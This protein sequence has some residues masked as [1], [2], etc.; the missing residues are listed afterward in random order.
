MATNYYVSPTGASGNAGTSGSP[1][2]VDTG[3]AHM[4]PDVTINFLPGTYTSRVWFP[5]SA[6]GS[7]GHPATIKSTVKWGAVVANI[8][9]VGI[10]APNGY[11]LSYIVIDGFR[12][13]GCTYD[14]VG[15]GNHS[16]V[17]NCWIHDNQQN[18]VNSTNVVCHDNLFEDNLIEYNGVDTVSY[19][20]HYHNIYISGVNNICRNNVIRYC[21]D[22]ADLIVYTGNVGEANTNNQ[23]YNNLVV[24]GTGAT[25]VNY[26][27]SFW[28]A[29]VDGSTNGGSP[30]T[31]YVFDNTFIGSCLAE[32][33]TL[34]FANNVVVP[35]TGQSA[36]IFSSHPSNFLGDYNAGP[37]T[38]L[39]TSHELITSVSAMSFVNAAHGL[40]WPGSGSSLRGHA[41][42]SGSPAPAVD[43]FGNAN[44]SITDIGFVQYNS[45][46]AGDTRTLDPSPSA[47]ADYWA[48]L[49]APPVDVVINTSPAS[50]TVLV[51]ATATFSVS[52]T[53]NTTL[54]Y[55]WRFNG[56]N[57]GTNSSTYSRTNCQLADSGGSVSVV[58]SDVSG[59]A[60]S[61]TAILTVNS[62]PPPPPPP[63]DIVI[64]QQPSS[65]S[66]QV[67]QTANFSVVA[68]GNSP[69][70]T[71]QWKFNGVNVGTNSA[72]YARTNCQLSDSGSHVVVVVTDGTGSL[73][74]SQ[75][76]LTVTSP[77]P[78]SVDVVIT[79]QPASTSVPV[80]SSATFS[81][82]ATGHTTLSY[83][84][85]FKGAN[86]GTNSASYTRPNC[87]QVDSGGAVQVTISDA[88][89]SV[90]S[91]SATLTVVPVPPPPPPPA[92]DIVITQPLTNQFVQVGQ[93][94][95]F[96]VSA[97]G[98][99]TLGYQWK[100]NG[101]TVGFNSPSYTR[102]NCQ[103]AD[104]GGVVQVTISD[105]SGTASSTASLGVVS[106][107]PPP[108]VITSPLAN[109][110]VQVGDPATFTV[111]ATGGTPTLTYQWTFNG[112]SVGS[113]SS[114]YTR[115]NCQ[116]V[117]NGG[118]VQVRVSNSGG[119]TL[120]SAVLG[121][122]SP[123]PPPPPPTTPDITIS[124]APQNLLVL[125]GAAATF[126]VS[127]SS[128][129]TLSYQWTFNG[130]NV[131]TNSAT[132][133]RT[134]CQLADDGGIVQVTITDITGS[135]SANA[136][137]SVVSPPPPPTTPD[138]IISAAP[139]SQLVH[140]GDTVVFS[141]SASAPGVLGYQWTFNG[142]P[143]G[144]NL[145]VYAR[146][147]CQ[148][149][150]NGGTVEVVVTD[151]SG[152]VAAIATLG[153]IPPTPPPPPPAPPVSDIVI[154]VQPRNQ[155]VQ[156]GAQA[157]FS[158]TALG[159]A[160]LT[161][162]WYFNG[163]IVQTGLSPI[164]K[165]VTTLFDNGAVVGVTVSDSLNSLVSNSA[166][167]T[168][169]VPA[170]APIGSTPGQS[171]GG[172]VPVH[173]ASSATPQV[174][175]TFPP[176]GPRYVVTITNP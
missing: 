84:W 24:G 108:P 39:G 48:P 144:G 47:G 148:L 95:T 56:S 104:N 31:N 172:N 113:N 125:V 96:T 20:T 17:R 77:P 146:V 41:N 78:P 3:L 117:D 105:A 155:S 85:T 166:V 44:P 52:A 62:P 102:T 90:V 49:S 6:S 171:T 30:G 74:S 159:A 55:Q 14:G 143:V 141:I 87:Q 22:G 59:S 122:A 106:P 161:Y 151:V 36:F 127:A 8:N 94:A 37:Q 160:V 80:G 35:T 119:S 32:Y 128:P 53:G 42:S 70:L 139:Q 9:T 167:L 33:G 152:S 134:N 97:T 168:V 69:P 13:H 107:P 67:G 149:S 86:V 58:V 153:V 103:L 43:F 11:N 165:R 164:Y 100:F 101:A 162:Q 65:Q 138:I 110:L 83:Q 21:H 147:N 131:G 92:V 175:T 93:S 73:T 76:T 170:P 2:D 150:D 89:G 126:S 98:G 154:F 60:V 114:S 5:S 163:T 156:A 7:A 61:G 109:K 111:V 145:P 26:T 68:T 137:L 64:Q 25:H 50:T 133:S 136:T 157:A 118:V 63:L 18:G 19:P 120:S 82:T 28:N 75:A 123:P 29:T 79:Q 1:W 124:T 142:T 38:I 140:V 112:V 12:V 130:S 45:T 135:V 158:I 88:S 72:S 132:Y 174:M 116:L 169:V 115:T 71:Y 173:S 121:V 16:V 27:A 40:Y 23:V 54:S 51:G 81:V 15:P 66:V 129:N 46:Y 4:G 91:S 10:N 57:V 34:Y 176:Q 99:T